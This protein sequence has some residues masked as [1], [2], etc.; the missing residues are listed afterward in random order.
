MGRLEMLRQ[1]E[2]VIAKKEDINKSQYDGLYMFFSF[3]LVNSTHFKSRYKTKWP[4]VFDEFYSNIAKVMNE[5]I[6]GSVVWKYIGDEVLFYKKVDCKEDLFIHLPKLIKIKDKVIEKINKIVNE[7]KGNLFIKTC[8]WIA[9]AKHIQDEAIRN[10]EINEYENLIRFNTN[11]HIQRY[12]T[13]IDTIDFIGT[14]IDS[15]F[16]ISK[17]VE[18]DKIIICS[19]LACCIYNLYLNRDPMESVLKECVESRLKIVTYKQLKGIWNNRYYPIIWYHNCWDKPEELLH[20]DDKYN[21][22]I[23]KENYEKIINNELEDITRI[24][25]IFEDLNRK[26]EIDLIM[27][28]IN[29]LPDK[30]IYKDE[31]INNDIIAYNQLSEVHCVA[32]CVNDDNEVLVAKRSNDKNYLPDTWEFGCGKLNLSET[33]EGCIIRSYKASFNIELNIKD[34]LIPISTYSIN[35]NN[36]IITGV[37]F[38]F[39]IKNTNDIKIS[40]KYSESRWIKYDS[41][42]LKEDNVVEGFYENMRLA[43]NILNINENSLLDK[44]V[45]LD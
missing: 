4:L 31:D 19:K 39:R 8:I 33:W 28:E 24:N 23:I 37:I 35:K 17:H 2:S 9:N 11:N 41:K 16:R 27:K 42:E 36:N 30:S 12:Y 26:Y 15:G 5:E 10:S 43:V 25:K 29:K 6:K 20:Y 13:T 38:A 7:S 34:R 22:D 18:K 45:A 3:D 40:S 32:I 44:Q 21:C 14:D 1:K